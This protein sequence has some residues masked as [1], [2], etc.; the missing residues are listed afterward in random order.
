MFLKSGLRP[1][2]FPRFLSALFAQRRQSEGEL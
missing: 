2:I 1:E